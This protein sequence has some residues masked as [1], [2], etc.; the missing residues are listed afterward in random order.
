MAHDITERK[1]A[2]EALR[3]THQELEMRVQERTRELEAANRDLK[4]ENEERLRVETELRES[5]THLRHLSSRLMSAQ[6][7]ERKR[8][9][10]ELHDG[11][12]QS[13]TSIKFK[14]E[15]FLQEI[16]R[17]TLKAK[18]KS[19]Q[20]VIPIIQQCVRE[21]HQIQM[22]L[23][24]A[25]LDDLGIGATLSWLCREFE[26][27]YSGI[28]IQKQIEIRES[29]V[30]EPL[31][32][33]LYRISQEALNNISKHSEASLIHISLRKTDRAIELSIE[34]NGRGFDLREVLS[35]EDSRQGIGL[36]SMRERAELIGGTF[37]IESSP[38]KGT[39][40]RGT[41]PL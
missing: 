17:S 40:M 6:E 39:K 13:L 1:R 29:D 20:D 26:A 15:S 32:M 10:R 21:S 14:V 11:L 34:D 27:T 2:E 28:R 33:A 24:P 16:G 4:T 8:I 30:P 9:A 7:Q 12:G 5:E 22:N 36:S 31:K 41:W 37:S 38:G 3:K 25:I 23:R 19:L 35:R 18:A